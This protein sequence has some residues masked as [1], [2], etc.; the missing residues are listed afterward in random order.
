[1]VR[2]PFY[3][4]HVLGFHLYHHFGY[5]CLFRHGEE[6]MGARSAALADAKPP[7]FGEAF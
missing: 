1:M 3:S 4:K 7:P 6:K 5:P 2:R